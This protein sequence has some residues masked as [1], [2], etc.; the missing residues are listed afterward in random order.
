MESV[1]S[2]VREMIKA[3]KKPKEAVAAALSMKRKSMKMADGGMV[4]D[5]VDSDVSSGYD[6]N[7]DRGLAE[8]QAQGESRPNEVENPAYQEADRMLAKALHQKSESAEMGYAMGGLVQPDHGMALG[9]K[10]SEDMGDAE[11]EE[12]MSDLSGVP[13]AEGHAMIDGAPQVGG[14]SDDAMKALAEKKKR[15]MFKQ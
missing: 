14:L 10:P 13:S 11:A 7:A 6:E 12:S 8:L 5:D 2:N 4:S 15:R 3:G 9:N 1:R